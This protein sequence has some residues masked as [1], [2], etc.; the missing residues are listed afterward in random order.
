MEAGAG[1]GESQE[2]KESACL[3]WGVTN[4]MFCLKVE[5]KHQNLIFS[6]DFRMHVLAHR[7]VM[8]HMLPHT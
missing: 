4:N 5:D 2:I 6:S 3:V 1:A 7:T 8:A